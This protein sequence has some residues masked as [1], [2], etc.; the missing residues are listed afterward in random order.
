MSRLRPITPSMASRSGPHH[1]SGVGPVPLASAL[2][3]LRSRR[4]EVGKE[5]SVAPRTSRVSTARWWVTPSTGILP[6]VLGHPRTAGVVELVRGQGA[7]GPIRRRHSNRERRA[8]IRSSEPEGVSI[9]RPSGALRCGDLLCQFRLTN[10]VCQSILTDMDIEEL[11][12]ESL[13]G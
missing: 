1:G 5:G 6:R 7:R 8:S 10:P 12:R 4:R 11:R 2:L 13:V 9:T 3:L